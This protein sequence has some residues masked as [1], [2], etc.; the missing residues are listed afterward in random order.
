MSMNVLIIDD[1]PVI[2]QTVY[3]QVT[4]LNMDLLEE[5]DIVGSAEEARSN[6]ERKEYQIFLCDIVMPNEDGI[7]FAKWVFK[8][9][10]YSKFIFLTA[11]SDFQYM[12]QAIS[13][14]SFDY[15]LQPSRSYELREV[16]QRAISQI[17][18]ESNNRILLEKASLY[19][20][21]ED[22]VVMGM[23]R[24]FLNGRRDSF[25]FVENLFWGLLPEKKQIRSPELYACI[26]YIQ[27]FPGEEGSEKPRVGQIKLEWE[28]ILNEILS[29]DQVGF[30]ILFEEKRDAIIF[31]LS[32]DKE[33]L[34]N[35]IENCWESFRILN[36]KINNTE[37][38]IYAEDVKLL[39]TFCGCYEKLLYR[40]DNNLK[41]QRGVYMKKDNVQTVEVR[42][43]SHL[44][45]NLLGNRD[46]QRFAES[47]EEIILIDSARGKIS[48]EYLL[49]LHECVTETLLSYMVN[50]TIDSRIVFDDGLPYVDY[51]NSYR[52]VDKFLEAIRYI[53]KKLEKEKAGYMDPIDTAISLIQ[54]NLYQP[55]SVIDLAKRVGMNSDY[56]TRVFKKRTGLNVKE[57]IIQEKMESAKQL[58]S[59]TYLPATIISSQLGYGSYSH[60]THSFK[61]IVGLTPLEYRK[62][63]EEK[64]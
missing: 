55:I 54:E 58:L 32:S 52:S 20:E 17:Q 8:H 62:Q 50:Q 56:L 5:I 27:I 39:Q 60:F 37:M 53:V 43:R 16:L 42:D 24:G 28:N 29:T 64:D 30:F 4:G 59:D 31:L 47:V 61:Q 63:T 13:M 33:F 49:S 14:K 3:E 23:V 35:G 34:E 45:A 7:S 41:E 19:Q 22:T 2:L 1:E 38:A 21:H 40:K 10:P 12:K 18:I 44:W 9:Y 48:K 51:M 6:L 46:Y 36:Y 11:H 26:G 15:L 57:Y 25:E